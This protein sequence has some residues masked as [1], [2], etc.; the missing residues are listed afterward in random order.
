MK[1]GIAIGGF[2]QRRMSPNYI[3]WVQL[4]QIIVKSTQIGQIGRFSLEN[5]I[6][7]GG[8]LGKKLV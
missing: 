8:K 2:H 6:L 7:M 1:F 3:N 4:G 5:G